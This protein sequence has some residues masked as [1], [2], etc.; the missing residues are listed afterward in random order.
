MARRFSSRSA[1]VSSSR[2][3]WRGTSR[4]TRRTIFSSIPPSQ[5]AHAL[6]IAMSSSAADIPRAAIESRLT[7]RAARGHV[8]EGVLG[9][10][11]IVLDEA[12]ALQ[13]ELRLLLELTPWVGARVLERSRVVGVVFD[14]LVHVIVPECDV[15]PARGRERGARN[16]HRGAIA[17]VRQHALDFAVHDE[18]VVS[19]RRIRRELGTRPGEIGHRENRQIAL[20]K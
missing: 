16:L 12:L 11:E 1:R 6:R 9:F 20:G 19:R 7:K 8:M 5:S 13:T 15:A 10:V 18:H 14:A 2:T 4:T 17:T 3:M